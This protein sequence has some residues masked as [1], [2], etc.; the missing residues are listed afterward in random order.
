M[1]E[2][3]MGLKQSKNRR[4]SQLGVQKEVS[5]VILGKREEASQPTL[6]LNVEGIIYGNPKSFLLSRPQG[7]GLN[8]GRKSFERSIPSS[9]GSDYSTR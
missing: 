9:A 6:C 8:S 5:K 7:V 4:R 2:S 1:S 3:G